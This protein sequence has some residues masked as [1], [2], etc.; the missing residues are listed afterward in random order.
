MLYILYHYYEY[1]PGNPDTVL[2]LESNK[3]KKE[4]VEIY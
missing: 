2:I 1:E 3:T 4:I